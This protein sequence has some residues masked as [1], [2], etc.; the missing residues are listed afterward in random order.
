MDE[1][2]EG[3]RVFSLEGWDGLLIGGPLAEG[4]LLGLI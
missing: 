4:A 1:G 3:L 2:K